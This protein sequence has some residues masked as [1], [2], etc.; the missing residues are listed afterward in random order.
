[1]AQAVATARGD[2]MTTSTVPFTS[3]LTFTNQNHL[4]EGILRFKN[5]NPS[6]LP[7]NEKIFDVPVRFAP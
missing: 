6:G 2:W 5:A 3:T 7:E 1:M 4:T